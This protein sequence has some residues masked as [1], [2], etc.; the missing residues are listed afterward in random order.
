MSDEPLSL[1]TGGTAPRLPDPAEDPPA[2][3]PA[4]EPARPARA[5]PRDGAFVDSDAADPEPAESAELDPDDPAE[6]VVSANATG[7]DATAEPTPNATANAPT[8][9]TNRAYP[10]VADSDSGFRADSISRIPFDDRAADEN[11]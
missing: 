3:S 8:R 9:P 10:D 11:D 6:P 2:E 4:A 7:T 5:G 1:A